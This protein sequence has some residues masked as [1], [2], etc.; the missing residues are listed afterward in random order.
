MYLTT[1]IVLFVAGALILV[2]IVNLVRTRRL[3]EE[4]ALL[5][6]AGGIGIVLAPLGLVDLLDRVAYA[7]RIE[8]PPTLILTLAIICLLGILMQFSLRISKF[9]EQ[10]KLLSQ[11]AALLARRVQELE[12]GQAGGPA[13]GGA[14]DG[15]A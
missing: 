8:Y 9:S 10:I 15:T 4:F 1:R 12:Q 11:E 7:I 14:H 3:K 5:W 2:F 13:N 6:L